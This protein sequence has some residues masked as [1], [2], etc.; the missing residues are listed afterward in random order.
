MVLFGEA[1]LRSLKYCLVFLT[2]FHEPKAFR[3]IL[4]TVFS[5]MWKFIGKQNK[6]SLLS[7]EV[8]VGSPLASLH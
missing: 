2:N 1:V 4:M 6:D 5:E 8:G 3:T 7:C